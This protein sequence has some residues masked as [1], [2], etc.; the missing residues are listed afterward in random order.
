VSEGTIEPLDVPIWY[1]ALREPEWLVAPVRSDAPRLVF[2]AEAWPEAGIDAAGQDLRLGVPTFL[3]EAAR[4]GTNA[5]PTVVE[6]PVTE[7]DPVPPGTTGVRS[8]VAPGGGAA[9]RVRVVDD[10]GAVLDEIVREAHDEATL[11][12]ALES[13]PYEVARASSGTGVKPVWNSTYALPGGAPLAAYVRGLHAARRL[14]RDRLGRHA[15]ADAV[16]S[17]RADVRA[18]LGALGTLAT[19][20]VEPFPALLFF[21]ALLAAHDA[22]S[23]V[24]GEFRLPANARC[25]TATDPVDPVYVLTALVTRVFGDLATSERRIDAVRATADPPLQRWLARVQAVT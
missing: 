10:A 21:G 14:D 12:S 19:S 16:A 3:A 15:D 17:R 11:G 1:A 23:P 22:G 13:L 20:T 7:D 2:A 9:V 18:T 24:V 6:E 8:A 4:F 5:W 25:T